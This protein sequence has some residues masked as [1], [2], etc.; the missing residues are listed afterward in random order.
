MNRVRALLPVILVSVCLLVALVIPN[1]SAI[2][3]P[4]SD[5]TRPSESIETEED[6]VQVDELGGN[7][8]VKKH[9]RVENQILKHMSKTCLTIR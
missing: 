5:Q 9:Q 2:E 6:T 1:A 4:G 3:K 8:S 7:Q